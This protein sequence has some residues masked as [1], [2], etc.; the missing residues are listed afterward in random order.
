M[1]DNAKYK[2]IQGVFLPEKD[3]SKYAHAAKFKDR[4]KNNTQELKGVYQAVARQ[5]LKRTILVGFGA[6]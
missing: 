6:H 5:D 3:D 1:L 2:M 4:L